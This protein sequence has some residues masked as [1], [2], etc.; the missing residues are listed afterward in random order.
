[1]RALAGHPGVA[2]SGVAR[3]ALHATTG[4]FLFMFRASGYNGVMHRNVIPDPSPLEI[5]QARKAIRLPIAT[6]CR[7]PYQFSICILAVTHGRSL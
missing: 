1:M 7:A 2:Q 4:R 6:T 5:H 3:M